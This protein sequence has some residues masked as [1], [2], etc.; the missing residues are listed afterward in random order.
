MK[1]IFP[2]PV[3][4]WTTGWQSHT[5]IVAANTAS[6]PHLPHPE[7]K[8]TSY[9]DGLWG[10]HE[11]TRQP[12]EFDTAFPYLAWIALP[13]DNNSPLHRMPTRAE[14]QPHPYISNRH[15]LSESSHAQLWTLWAEIKDHFMVVA[16]RAAHIDGLDHLLVPWEA[17]RRLSITL[18][19]LRLA[20]STWRDIVECVRTAQ[21]SILEIHAFLAYIK[22]WETSAG[23][24]PRPAVF[25]QPT[26]GAII[27]DLSLYF[28]FTRLGIAIFL[29]L[30]EDEWEPLPRAKYVQ[31]TQLPQHST[32]PIS[33]DVSISP[34]EHT[35]EIWHYPPLVSDI[36]YFE[37]AARGYAPRTDEETLTL[38]TMEI[39]RRHSLR[40]QLQPHKLNTE[41]R[42]FKNTADIPSWVPSVLAEWSYAGFAKHRARYDTTLH[43]PWDFH[44]PPI[45]LFWG[46]DSHNQ[47][48][49]FFHWQCIEEIWMLRH[50]G[51]S[52]INALSRKVFTTSDW[53]LYL[54]DT[55]WKRNWPRH[56]DSQTTFQPAYDTTRFW[57]VGCSDL[58]GN[59]NSDIMRSDI[60]PKLPCG[61][62]LTLDL[63]SKPDFQ[64]WSMYKLNMAHVYWDFVFNDEMQCNSLGVQQ[65]SARRNLRNSIW[66]TGPYPS[67]VSNE[68]HPFQSRDTHTRRQWF[69]LLVQ[70]IRDWKDFP[71]DCRDIDFTYMDETTYCSIER[72]LT[73]FYAESFLFNYGYLPARPMFPPQYPNLYCANH[74]HYHR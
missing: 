61:C 66:S 70:V 19:R 71:D 65:T 57:T 44:L 11:W 12:Q 59:Q 4:C 6:I 29:E 45:H 13:L 37:R 73:T 22:D 10:I 64:A 62:P 16:C 7:T 68:E 36:V 26:R 43:R 32:W 50:I 46:V 58:F 47:T 9:T 40:A 25:R 30:P 23:K 5:I 24:T 3:T 56:P 54:S 18:L 2:Y 52:D 49:F 34:T 74:Q 41:A 55:Y 42:R 17:T 33:P 39:M 20:P 60:V 53:R 35:K 69:T 67:Q 28:D 1:R 14:L 31:K 21:R 15:I 48:I 63:A 27:H 51:C 72:K 38:R 8:P